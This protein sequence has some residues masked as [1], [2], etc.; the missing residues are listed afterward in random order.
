MIMEIL[1]FLKLQI[2][3]ALSFINLFKQEFLTFT[4]VGHF[5]RNSHL[6]IFGTHSKG[7]GKST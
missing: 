7:G 5:I 3:W 6:I 4:C 1:D 2:V